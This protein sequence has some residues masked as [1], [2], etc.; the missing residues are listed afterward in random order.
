MTSG[1]LIVSQACK[2]EFAR[3]VVRSCKSPRVPERLQV[4]IEIDKDL[5]VVAALFV[6]VLPSRVPV[7][8]FDS[9]EHAYNHDKQIND[10]GQPLLSSKI[11]RESTE[12]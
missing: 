4:G 2:D 3:Q 7:C 1:N 10:D 6:T 12:E 5:A 8:G 11:F 9:N